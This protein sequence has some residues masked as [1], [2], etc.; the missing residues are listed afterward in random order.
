M[1]ADAVDL[2]GRPYELKV[3]AGAEPDEI[4][5]EGSQLAAT[6]PGFFLVVISNLEGGNAQPR[7]RIILDPLAQLKPSERT[8]IPFSG[9]RSSRS[10]VYEF[11]PI[12]EEQ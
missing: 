8:S 11:A 1:G 9:V 12:V 5:L 4:M 3:N 10:L 7:V 2:E 6:T